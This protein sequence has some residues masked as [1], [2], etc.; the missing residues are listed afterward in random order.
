[1]GNGGEWNAEIKGEGRYDDR[2]YLVRNTRG[3]RHLDDV[4]VVELK[5]G[6]RDKMEV[7]HRHC[8]DHQ[9][10]ALDMS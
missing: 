7:T 6:V 4:S 3:T 1:M 10:C 9:A 8:E 5:T 2:E